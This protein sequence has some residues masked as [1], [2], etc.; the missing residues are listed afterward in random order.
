MNIRPVKTR[1]FREWEGLISFITQHV[2][3]LTEGSVLAV[4]SKIVAL[5]EGR[6]AVA[7]T[8]AQ[9]KKIIKAE[10]TWTRPSK[11]VLLTLKD[12]MLLP[13]AGVDESNAAGPSTQLGVKNLVL[14]PL[15]SFKAARSL[16]IELRTF[17]KVKKLGVVLTDSRVMPMRKGVLGVALGYAGFKGIR[18]Y[19]G[20]K[21]LF[22]RTMKITWQ[23][24]PDALATAAALCMGEGNE[25]QPLAV[26]E[27]APV[28]FVERVNRRE[29]LI[30]PRQDMYSALFRPMQ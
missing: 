12:G 10:S 7:K 18:D 20:K 8:E 13:N 2:P 9:R 27:D 19:R 5:S 1:I 17:Y 29:L 28:E 30:D 16:C 14:L 22:G 21:D 6:T 24:I 25:R 4:T 11:L 23:N 26:I 15:D 3:K